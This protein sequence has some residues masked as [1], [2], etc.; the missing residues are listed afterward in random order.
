MKVVLTGAGGFIG[1]TLA[2]LLLR[3]GYNG[4][5]DVD[6]LIL[7]DRQFPSDYLGNNGRVKIIEGEVTNSS[8]MEKAIGD[9]SDWVIH[10]AATLVVHAEEKFDEGM[11]INFRAVEKILNIC[12]HAKK[13]VVFSFRAQLRCS[14]EHFLNL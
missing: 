3:Y 4:M 11:D 12:R 5:N 10:L 1:T 8:L 9:D 13:K 2:E 7:I 6:E 14:A